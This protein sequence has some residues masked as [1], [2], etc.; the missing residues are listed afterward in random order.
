MPA[1]EGGPAQQLARN[2]DPSNTYG[3]NGSLLSLAPRMIALIW[4]L[5]KVASQPV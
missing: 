3:P 2:R 1:R 5:L 4:L